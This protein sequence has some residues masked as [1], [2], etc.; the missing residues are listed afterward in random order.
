LPPNK[1]INVATIIPNNLPKAFDRTAVS[2]N[3]VIVVIDTSSSTSQA[4]DKGCVYF[5]KQL[6]MKVGNGTYKD[7]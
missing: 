4:F 2:D 5:R 7:F 3:R 1:K 6:P